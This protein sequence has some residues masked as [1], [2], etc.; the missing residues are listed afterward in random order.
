MYR[1]APFLRAPGR[2]RSTPSPSARERKPAGPARAMVWASRCVDANGVRARGMLTG[3]PGEALSP[4]WE[5]T[6]A[7][8]FAGCESFLRL[9]RDA[10]RVAGGRDLSRV[11]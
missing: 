7:P 2:R 1:G 9:R 4:F 10:T 11:R 5:D 8:R 6:L 3:A